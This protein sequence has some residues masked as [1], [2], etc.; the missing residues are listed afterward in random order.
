MFRRRAVV[1][2]LF[3]WTLVFS[4]TLLTYLESSIQLRLIPI[5]LNIVA[6]SA[7]VPLL[8]K[9]ASNTKSLLLAL[10]WAIVI[11]I[12]L[13]LRTVDIIDTVAL[14]I[15]VAVMTGIVTLVWCVMSH[16]E[17]VT[18]SGFHWYVWFMLAILSLCAACYSQ[19]VDTIR[20]YVVAVAVSFVV[21][22]FYIM[23]VF[24][25]QSSGIERCQHL[26]RIL[27]CFALVSAIL[28]S[29]ILVSTGTVSVE[30]WQ[31]TIIALEA[32]VGIVIIVDSVIGFSRLP[33]KQDYSPLPNDVI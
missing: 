21:H 22:C 26:F 30:H 31:Q 11:S 29:S 27:S 19:T 18:E 4:Y 3:L 25:I 10:A 20:I 32:V 5:A 24:K 15:H 12:G 6:C 33:I 7:L 14:N 23:H 16:A 13:L 28:I 8:A 2:S 1:W 17:H 9:D